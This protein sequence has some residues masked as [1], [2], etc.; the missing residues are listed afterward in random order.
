MRRQRNN[1]AA[2]PGD[3][4]RI[5]SRMIYDGRTYDDIRTEMSGRTS[6][7]L[8]NNSFKAWQT[9]D[10]YT[11]Y[12]DVRAGFDADMAEDQVLA[13]A[14]N[15]GRGPES[16]LDLIVMDVLK[17]LRQSTRDNGIVDAD[18]LANVTKTIA[19]LLRNQVAEAKLDADTRL[20][21][22][23]EK[24]AAEIAGLKDSIAVTAAEIDRLRGILAANRIDPDADSA[25]AGEGLSPAALAQIEEKAK[26]L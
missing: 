14:I 18:Q 6:V 13:T 24:H 20:K 2:L 8:H 25:K 7:K 17:S 22:A 10:E 26:L 1:I 9:S 16:A 15:D 19:P 3:L 23:E 11:R 12:R 4:R 5:V 21:K